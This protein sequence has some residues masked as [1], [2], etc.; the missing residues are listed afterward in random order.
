MKIKMTD[1]IPHPASYKDPSGFVF[2]WNGLYYRHV[3]QSYSADY[4]RLMQS[5]LYKALTDKKLLIPHEEINENPCG[6]PNWYKTL[7][8]L[9]LQS[10]SHASEWTPGQLRDAALLILKTMSIS[11]EHGMILKDATPF[12][13]Q[14]VGGRPTLIDTLSFEKY[15]TT[16]PWIAYRQ[17]CE[18][19]L[20]PLY[21]N[22]YLKNGT[23]KI[24]AAYPNGIP[25]L[26]TAKI[27]PVKSFLNTGVFLHVYLQSRL[28]KNI[29]TPDQQKPEFTEKKLKD[30][31]RN[32]ESIVKGLQTGK[33]LYSDWSGYYNNNI[34]STTYLENKEK[35][36]VEFINAIPFH[37]ALDLG[38]NNGRFSLLLAE[39]KAEVVA[40]DADW[41][42]VAHLYST[43]KEKNIPNILPLCVDIANPT[44]ATGF[45]HAERASFSERMQSDL[46]VALALV[47]HLVFSN[48]IPLPGV[49]TCLASLTKEYLLVEFILAEDEKVTE[50]LRHKDRHHPYNIQ[51]FEDS[52]KPWFCIEKKRKIEGSDRVLYLMK[53]TAAP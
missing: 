30:I 16:R 36:F 8:P 7:L 44:P 37:S 23:E 5:G 29:N 19:F 38:A 35:I 9:Q 42:S 50:L 4:D 13:I 21:L 49:A 52:F 32:L 18:C 46:V 11:I 48:N 33:I 41:Q 15:D 10:I 25:A 39:Q 51:V 6:L 2:G 47:H 22:H 14:F 53:K 45:Q 31:L 27:L 20:F 40:V 28:S 12:N 34:L 1:P 3:D 26:V 17:F 43:I 24:Y